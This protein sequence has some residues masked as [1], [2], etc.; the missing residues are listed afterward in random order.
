MQTRRD[1]TVRL[2]KWMLALTIVVPAALFSYFAITTYD[3]S[4]ALADER[5]QRSLDV[6]EEHAAKVFESLN[7]I[8]TAINGRLRDLSDEQIRAAQEYVHRQFKEIVAAMTGVDAIW[9]FDR[10]GRPV[11]SS[12]VYPVPGDLSVSDRDYFRA[13]I[14][15]DIGV[16]VSEVL[17]P[18]VTA[19]PVFVVSRRRSVFD[20]SFGGVFI[21]SLNPAEFHKFYARLAALKGSNYTMVRDDGLVLVRYPGLITPA[22]RLDADSGFMQSIA[23]DRAGGFYTTVSQVD[24]S[25]RRIAIRKLEGLPVYISTGL[26]VADIR[27]EWWSFL[28]S[29]L[30]VGVP[31]TLLLFAL[32]WAT[33]RRTQDFHAE[34]SRRMA[35]EASLRQS[36]KMEAVGHLTGGVAHD[37]NNLLTV[38]NGN[39]E[40][41]LRRTVDAPVERLLRNALAGG[42][43]AAQLTKRLLAFSRRQPLDPQPVDANKMIADMSDLLQRSLGERVEIEIVGSAGLWRTEVDPA[44]LEAA[45]L[46]LAINARDAM[47]DGGK[48][49]IE[50]S[51]A[52]L[53]E[54]YARALSDVSAGQY[55]LISV[56]DNGKGM[57]AEV[58]SRAFEPFFT[59]KETGKG[60]GLGLSQVYGFCKQSGGHAQI[61]SE[62]GHGTT[63]KLY[64][65]RQRGQRKSTDVSSKETTQPGGGETILVVE[66]DEGVRTYLAEVLAELGYQ[67]LTAEDGKAALVILEQNER[68]IDL[69]LTDVVLPGMNGRQLVDLAKD[70]RPTLRVLYMTGYSRNAI[71]HHG[72]LDAG[73][74]LIQKPIAQMELALKIRELLK[75]AS[76]AT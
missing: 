42:Q 71:V 15:R 5:I 26:G 61:Y 59:T 32:V 43:R 48:L 19:T 44:E 49:T 57:P 58:L 55:V 16:Y 23:R 28:R 70:H 69:L 68:R 60:S 67:V 38:I 36:Q 72:R 64:L 56:S 62:E 6:V 24:R 27:E 2:L 14:E 51:N 37:F 31:A 66:D 40:M 47:P 13:H 8:S 53:D 30:M 18:R 29:Q 35:A 39:L 20:G 73:V 12:Y 74:A 54:S 17:T 63:V 25:E 75:P 76:V 1:A 4:F 65:P 22:V 50:T 3:A 34:A 33:L 11:A 52:F 46:N 21:L 45:I 7:V 9:I 41:A 10:N